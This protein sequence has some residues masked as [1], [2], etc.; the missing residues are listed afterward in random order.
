[1]SF[2]TGAGA[3][4]IPLAPGT[5]G[6]LV[7]VALFFAFSNLGFALYVASVAALTAIGV[8][9]S[10]RAGRHF[11]CEDDGRIVIDEVVGQLLTLAPLVVLKDLPLGSVA[12]PYGDPLVWQ[13]GSVLEFLGSGPFASL[14]IFFLL[15]VTGFVLFRLLDIWKPGAIGWAERKFPGGVGVMADDMMAGFFGAILLTLP[16]YAALAG[17]LRRIAL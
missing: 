13:P 10:E 14:D 7:G 3:G 17:L 9:A 8:W 11:A 5:F 1:M 15:V 16:A 12:A 2:A 4:Y 6:S